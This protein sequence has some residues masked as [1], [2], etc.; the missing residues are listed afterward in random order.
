MRVMSYVALHFE[1]FLADDLALIYPYPHHWPLAAVSPR[2]CSQC[3]RSCSSGGRRRF[4][5]LAVGW[6]WFLGTLVPAIG[7]VQAGVQSM[8][9]RYTYLPGIGLFIIVVWGLND[10]LNSHLQKTKIAALAGALRSPAAWLSL[11]SS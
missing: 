3:G 11:P 8:A 1:N 7:L 9:D 2:F 5:Y 10:L 6:F 4:P